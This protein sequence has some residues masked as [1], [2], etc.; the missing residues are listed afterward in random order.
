MKYPGGKGQIYQKIINLIPPHEVFIETHLGGGAV[1]RNKRPAKH[2]IGIEIDPRVIKLWKEKN[3][4][5][6]NHIEIIQGDAVDYL[7]KYNFTGKEFLY[8]DPPYLQ[9]TKRNKR[10]RLYKFDYTAQQHIQLL[11]LIKTLNC[12][13]M[14]SGYESELYKES[15]K[16]WYTKT[17]I[18]SCHHGIATEWLWMNYSCPIELHDYRYLG[19]NFRQRERIKKKIN[20]WTTKLKSMPILER[21]A[22]LYAMRK[23]N[24]KE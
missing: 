10:K 22:L 4:D 17:F 8:C 13:I 12:K 20:R 16:A 7:K 18:A 1:I 3:H 21:Q 14:I 19:D 11:T 5:H 15:L 2:N 24:E 23:L 9:E 6:N